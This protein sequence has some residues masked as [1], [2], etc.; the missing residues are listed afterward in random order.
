[1]SKNVSKEPMNCVSAKDE[2]W[3]VAGSAIRSLPGMLFSFRCLRGGCFL[4]D[5]AAFSKCGNGGDVRAINDRPY[6][7]NDGTEEKRYRAVPRRK[8]DILGTVLELPVGAAD[9]KRLPKRGALI[10]CA[11]H[12]V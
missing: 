1:M 5:V 12:K 3:F 11:D 6:E 2:G 10:L 7:R 4:V 8:N 9:K